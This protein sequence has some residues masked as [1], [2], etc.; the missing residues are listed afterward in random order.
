MVKAIGQTGFIWLM[1]SKNHTVS[2]SKTRCVKCI[3]RQLSPLAISY[4]CRKLRIRIST[5]HNAQCELHTHFNNRWQCELS[6]RIEIV[7]ISPQR[8]QGQAE[9][10]T[11]RGIQRLVCLVVNCRK[12]KQTRTRSQ[13]NLTTNWQIEIL[14]VNHGRRAKP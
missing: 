13:L 5:R 10:Y 11:I 9:S 12:C 8:T 2:F 1:F 4:C 14:R 7:L 3:A 6:A